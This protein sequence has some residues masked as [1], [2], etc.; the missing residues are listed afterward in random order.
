MVWRPMSEAENETA[1][2]RKTTLKTKAAPKSH[3]DQ[4]FTLVAIYV[5]Y[6]ILSLF[7]LLKAAM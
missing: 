3:R 4:N 6:F 2:R 5:R 1:I 7:L